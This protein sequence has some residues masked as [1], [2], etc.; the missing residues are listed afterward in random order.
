MAL[1]GHL[2]HYYRGVP[3]PPPLVVLYSFPC[4]HGDAACLPSRRSFSRLALAGRPREL[5]P[6]LAAARLVAGYLAVH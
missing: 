1:A 4:S 5:S 6:P 2:G 3:P